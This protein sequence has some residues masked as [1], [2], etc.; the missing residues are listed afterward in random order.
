MA[1][2]LRDRM[3]E[4]RIGRAE[5]SARR[6]RLDAGMAAPGTG[7]ER[8][9]LAQ[10]VAARWNRRIAEN[11]HHDRTGPGEPGPV[12]GDLLLVYLSRARVD[13]AD[14]H[15]RSEERRVGK[16]CRSRWSPYH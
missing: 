14:I 13:Q 4:R 15:Q 16:E 11:A 6:H 7:A 8:L 3:Q 9:A 10:P 12:R 2:E 1:D 5:W